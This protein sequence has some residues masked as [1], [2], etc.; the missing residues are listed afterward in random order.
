[1]YPIKVSFDALLNVIRYHLGAY[2]IIT[3]ICLYKNVIIREKHNTYLVL[4]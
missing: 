4:R 3:V 1:M 2:L